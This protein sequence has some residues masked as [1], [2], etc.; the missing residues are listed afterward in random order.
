MEYKSIMQTV[1]ET[2]QYLADAEM[3]LGSDGMGEILEQIAANPDVGDVMAGTGGFR[4]VRAARPGMGKRGGARVIYIQRG[5]EYPI[6]LV[7]AYAK[8]VKENL[9][10]AER[11]T[12]KQAADD[13]FERY[14]A[15]R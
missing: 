10:A 15:R 9:T 3:L 8:N 2:P 7:K 5:A 13:I 6:F 12:L 4:K 11:K 1:V 14:G